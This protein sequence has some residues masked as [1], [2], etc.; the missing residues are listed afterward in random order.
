MDFRG[1]AFLIAGISV[2]SG[3]PPAVAQERPVESG[4]MTPEVEAILETDPLFVDFDKL[5]ALTEQ[6]TEELK[7]AEAEKASLRRRGGLLRELGALQWFRAEMRRQSPDGGM[8]EQQESEAS[9]KRAVEILARVEDDAAIEVIDVKLRQAEVVASS[10]CYGVDCEEPAIGAAVLADQA[11]EEARRAGDPAWIARALR[12]NSQVRRG[13]QLRSAE[14]TGASK[15]REAVQNMGD[16]YQRVGLACKEEVGEQPDDSAPVERQ[17]AWSMAL[18][19]CMGRMNMN[20]CAVAPPQE[21]EIE[22]ENQDFTAEDEQE[23]L[24]EA[25]RLEPSRAG[26]SA[27]RI[28]TL[29]LLVGLRFRNDQRQ[30]ALPLLQEA[31]TGFRVMGLEGDSRFAG[32]LTRYYFATRSQEPIPLD[33]RFEGQR[34]ADLFA[35]GTTGNVDLD[36]VL[37]WRAWTTTSDEKVGIKL[38]SLLLRQGQT[39]AIERIVERAL[40]TYRLAKEDEQKLRQLRDQ[41]AQ[42]RKEIGPGDAI[43]ARPTFA[44]LPEGAVELEEPPYYQTPPP[45]QRNPTSCNAAELRSHLSDLLAAEKNR[46][47]RSLHRQTESSLFGSTLEIADQDEVFASVVECR[48][49]DPEILRTSVERLLLRRQLWRQRSSLLQAA[50]ERGTPEMLQ[51]AN[52]LVSLR[53]LRSQ[54]RLR[55]TEDL[56]QQLAQT[57]RPRRLDWPAW[58]EPVQAAITELEY[59]IGETEK[60]LATLVG[61]SEAGAED[62]KEIW[63]RLLKGLGSDGALVGYVPVS[64]SRDERH[65]VGFVVTGSGAV[66]WKDLGDERR[67]AQ[68]LAGTTIADRGEDLKKVLRQ[69]GAELFDPLENQ[70]QGRRRIL[71]L[72]SGPTRFLPWSALEDAKGRYLG[73]R[74]TVQGLEWIGDATPWTQGEASAR[75]DLVLVSPSYPNVPARTSWR[76]VPSSF[77]ALPGALEELATVSTTLGNAGV[78]VREISGPEATEEELRGLHSPMLVHIAAHGFRRAEWLGTERWLFSPWFREAVSES[79]L[80]RAGVAL[81]G[82]N[83]RGSL[84]EDDGLLTAGEAADLDLRGTSLVV[85]SGCE[86][87]LPTLQTSGAAH[88]LSLGFRMAGAQSVV[89]SLWRTD[90]RATLSL[91]SELYRLLK[92]GEPVVEALWKA[93]QKVRQEPGFE[94]PRFWAAFEVFGRNVALP[95]QSKR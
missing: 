52:L 76:M 42:Q 77:S 23:L 69:A 89:A 71:L 56:R 58:V 15:G 51:K 80:L 87:G 17:M 70:I 60:E 72:M 46:I 24:T 40:G 41:G 95:I 12:V 65:L 19:Q 32:T 11:L 57:P 75:G 4:R 47:A 14:V 66:S 39:E 18:I 93:K 88:D 27:G 35:R 79:S 21:P 74:F 1:L 29:L 28:E 43:H 33:P 64:I 62:L 13:L 30:E 48:T 92:T 45:S 63:A 7:Q 50:R 44:V 85:L 81:S 49:Q 38:G 90:D 73:E 59:S 9:F 26:W 3:L 94:D 10:R 67:V 22:A 82:S 8:R 91:M 34:V 55:T 37:L 36:L 20:G 78:S 61:D 6:R 53:N 54:L 2:L 31:A 83:R 86:T 84:E 25:L 5:G 16:C 68:G